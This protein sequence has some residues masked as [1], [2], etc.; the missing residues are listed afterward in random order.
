MDV[1]TALVE[2]GLS[3]RPQPPTLDVVG[4]DWAHPT[5][6]GRGVVVRVTIR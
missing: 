2:T 3:H 6:Y 4:V 5:P 1:E